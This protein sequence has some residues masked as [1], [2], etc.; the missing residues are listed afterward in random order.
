MGPFRVLRDPAFD[1][2]RSEAPAMMQRALHQGEPAAVAI[3]WVAYT[4]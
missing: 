1:L 3:L 4:Q 2:W